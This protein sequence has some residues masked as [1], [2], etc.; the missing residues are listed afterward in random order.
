[1][2]TSSNQEQNNY[3]PS[4]NLDHIQTR[5]EAEEAIEELRQAL[6]FHNYK[7]YIEDDPVASDTEYDEWMNQLQELESR[8]PELLTP[9]SPSQQVGG[10]PQEELGLAEHPIPMLSLQSISE[11]EEA[12]HFDKTCRKE[13]GVDKLAYSCEPKYDGLA[14]E[15]IY[16]GGSLDQAIT[17]GDG[18]T[19]E[20]VTENVKTIKEVPLRLIQHGDIPIP[21]RLVV[22]G[23]IYMRKDRFEELNRRQAESDLK[24][25]ANPRNAAAGS[26]RQLDPKIAASRP[27]Q[28]FFY[29]VALADGIEFTNQTEAL[30]SLPAWGLKINEDLNR[31]CN[32]ID[33]VIDQYNHLVD[34]RD[35]LP[36]EI[37]GMVCKVDNISHQEQLGYRTNNPRWAVAYK[38]PARQSTSTIR[39][40][41]VQVGRTGRLTPIAILDPVNIGGVEVRRASLHNQSEIDQKDIRIGDR[42]VVERAGDVIPYVVKAITEERGG[43]EKTFKLP[44]SC[45]VCGSEVIMSEDKK[46]THCTNKNCPAQLREG[47]KH[48]V[49]INGMDIEG[50]GA[51]RVENLLDLELLERVS[52]LF[53]LK[54][55]EWMRLEDVAEKSADNILAELEV[56]KKQPLKRFLFA[57][58]IPHVGQHLSRVLAEHFET[59]DDLEQAR[60]EELRQ[61][62]E[63]GPEV[64][65]SVC[66]FFKNDQNLQDIERMRKAGLTLENPHYSEQPQPLAGLRFVFTGSLENWSR[67]EI[68]E[69]VEKYGGR[70]T[71]SVSGQTDYL[72]AGPGAGSK[73]DQA[74]EL[75]VT[76]LDEDEFIQLMEEKGVAV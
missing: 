13:L 42:V 48:F 14:I 18:E 60:E 16:N 10:E 9:D 70:T 19:G 27:L 28:I 32:N 11:E 6:R 45:P 8:Y 21:E 26:I 37:D 5:D 50:L 2:S 76:V 75:G 30:L 66:L 39:E 15:L 3:R 72:V 4:V 59:I 12:R 57:I 69:I 63:I 51:K 62:H 41:K 71:S 36:Y 73:L 7:Y 46:Q 29:H 58:G 22:R 31:K 64:A 1:M 23:E 49:S 40:I 34:I 55:E 74:N 20:E 25:F 17:R 53:Y 61:I 44:D 38:F 56:A 35:E 67:N 33:E 65:R 52:D 68:Q 24:T 54:R 43:S 47:V